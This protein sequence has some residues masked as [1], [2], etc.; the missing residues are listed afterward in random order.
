MA[1]QL[2]VSNSLE[3]LS[4]QLNR[5][6]KKRNLTVF[7]PC[8]VVTQTVGMNNWLKLQVADDKEIKIAANIRFLK[9]NDL[10][11]KVYGFVGG[12]YTSTYSADNLCWLLFKILGE[13]DFINK[14]PA[15]AAYY[16]EEEI[17]NGIRQM[18]L[19]EKLSDL[20]DQ[21]QI[22]RP[23]LISDWNRSSFDAVE[24]DGWQQ[25]IWIRAKQLAGEKFLDKTRLGADILALLQNPDNVEE[26]TRHLPE[27]HVFGISILTAYH[28]ELLKE[29]SKHI[30][31]HIYFLNPAPLQ[32]WYD[33]VNEKQQAVLLYKGVAQPG[34]LT[35]GNAL[36]T[37]WGKV[38]KE[39]FCLLFEH[40]EFLNGFT[41]AGV[42]EPV[43]DSLLKKIQHDIFH[44]YSTKQRAPLGQNDI[45]DGSV[46]IQSCYT[47]ARE[48]ESLYNYL[49]HLV[50]QQKEKLSPRD[51]VVMVTDV[52]AFAPYIKAVFDNA[53]YRFHYT[54]ADESFTNSDNIVHALK[55]ILELKEEDFK[56]E[57]IV[58]LLDSAPIRKRLGIT[59]ITLIRKVVNMANIRFGIEGNKENDT[60]YVSWKYGLQRILYGIC[61]SG[62]EEYAIEEDTIFP[63]DIAEGADAKELICFSHF[64]QLLIE[65][66][67]KRKGPRTISE[68]IEYVKIVVQSLVYEPT[69]VVEEDYQVLLK[70][71]QAFGALNN[72]VAEKFSYEV[73]CYQFIQ[74][75]SSTTRSS[76]FI[77]GGITFCSLI[78]MRSIPFK[79]VALLGLNFDQFPRK[80]TAASFNLIQQHWKR[81]DRNMKDND[82]HLFLE[83][84]LSAKEYLYL[85][86]Q[87]QS[88]KDNSFLPPSAL[89]DELLDYIE[90]RYEGD[91]EVRK[92]MVVRQPL[93]SFSRR[94]SLDS[95]R[96]YNYLIENGSETIRLDRDKQP[97]PVQIKEISLRSLIDFFKNPFK[98][99]YN[100]VL[101]I[102]YDE[103]T[104]LLSETELFDLDNLQQWSL[105]QHVLTLNQQERE[106]FKIKLVKQGKLPLK[107]MAEIFLQEIEEAVNPV[108]EIFQHTTAGMEPTSIPVELTIDD[109]QITGTIQQVYNNQLV[110]VSFSKNECKYQL[111]AY[112]Q[113]L[114]G[115]ATG[116]LE[117][118]CFIS[119]PKEQFYIAMSIT[120]EEAIQRLKIL[121]QLYRQGHSSLVA[122]Y[123]GFKIKPDKVAELDMEQFQR[124]VNDSLNNYSFPFTDK[125]IINEYNNGFFDCEDAFE[126]FKA[127]CQLLL[128][129]LT[130]LFPTYYQ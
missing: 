13:E 20:F 44:N 115:R 79:V 27:A 68:W 105:K 95:E 3:E 6:F 18:A 9:P 65:V 60:V 19:A 83:T 124:V 130:E 87:G 84:V 33:T 117:G 69:D 101:N 24:E 94:Y 111:E 47:I 107:N 14:F 66:M 63:L 75:L 108:K 120:K 116:T 55:M 21:Y 10:L 38:I 97:E 106:G 42:N 36:L 85:S 92:K 112:I 89:V 32:Y 121:V 82:K 49:V 76:S 34:D 45:K 104:D 125:Y 70:Q 1:L 53:P 74:T 8:Y 52:D 4:V 71:L 62:E 88:V 73:F 98:T 114:I 51:I 22:Y 35:V 59:N 128:T 41:E 28:I 109:V 119:T 103:D 90:A 25:Y 67:E 30:D 46:T 99:Y 61:M 122:F 5:Q 7:Q 78:P 127:N 56:A 50:D 81:G 31:I 29:L 100:Q 110:F 126:D 11:H 113:Y 48:V 86:Y 54:I 17:S 15:I 58:Q 26:L 23:Q 93:H 2:Y 16:I 43:S 37:G 91:G 57:N 64:V 40:D 72:V 39:T 129:P 123:P 12:T 77:G 118:L 96:L 80:E 102:R